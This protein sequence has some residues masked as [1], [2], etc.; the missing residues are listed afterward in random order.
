MVFLR[1]FNEEHMI[2]TFAFHIKP[3]KLRK[4]FSG[5]LPTEL[6]SIISAFAKPRLRYPREYK[7]ALEWTGTRE[8][9]ELM[10]K[11]MDDGVIDV[12]RKYLALKEEMR[13]AKRAHSLHRE[14]KLLNPVADSYENLLIAV[15]GKPAAGEVLPWT[16][17]Y[18]YSDLWRPPIED[19]EESD[20]DDDY[21]DPLD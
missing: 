18:P 19:D 16:W 6:V 17:W 13:L 14:F 2:V 5:T 10:K 15:Y 7:E 12:L 20:E 1:E 9:P 8:W 21:D 4:R 11:L 3:V